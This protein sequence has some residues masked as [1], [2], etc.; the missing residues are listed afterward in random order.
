[1]MTMTTPPVCDHHLNEGVSPEWDLPYKKTNYC[2][3][4]ILDTDTV[5][6]LGKVVSLIYE[7]ERKPVCPGERLECRL[8][9]GTSKG[10]ATWKSLD[11]YEKTIAVTLSLEGSQGAQDFPH[12][13]DMGLSGKEEGC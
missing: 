12:F 3:Y 8:A 11:K 2:S 9:Q 7:A 5:S 13:R 1:M 6:D 4:W 10:S